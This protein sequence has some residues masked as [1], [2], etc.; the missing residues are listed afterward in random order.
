MSGW[1]RASKTLAGWIPVLAAVVAIQ[2]MANRGVLDAGK[3]PKLQGEMLVDGVPFSGLQSLPKPVMVYFWASWC[4]ICKAMQ[5]TV[6][7]VAS[8]TPII[9]VAMQSGDSVTV[10]EYMSR[11]QFEV[12]TLIDQ[13]G[14]LAT[15]YGVRGVP[16]A[17]I[18]DRD[19]SIRSAT[20]GYTSELG[21][22]L[23]LWW[24]NR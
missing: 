7:A 18:V 10:R 11:Q 20:T 2:L 12:P 22:R 13:E 3:A 6:M 8:D 5:S 14:R 15:M 17:F 9:T 4:G 16:A 24:A 23:R 19:G 1:W 21:L